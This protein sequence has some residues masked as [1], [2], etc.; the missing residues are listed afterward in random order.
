MR[1]LPPGYPRNRKAERLLRRLEI[2]ARLQLA[3]LGL[4]G[5]LMLGNLA[6]V[7]YYDRLTGWPWVGLI[8]GALLLASYLLSRWGWRLMDG[9]EE[10]LHSRHEWTPEPPEGWRPS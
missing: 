7:I 9:I 3:L 1:G 6:S 5:G 8:V 10:S 2:V 4:C